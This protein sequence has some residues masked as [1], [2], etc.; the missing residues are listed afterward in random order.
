MAEDTTKKPII[1]ILKN[2]HMASTRGDRLSENSKIHSESGLLNEPNI[3]FEGN[4]PSNIRSSSYVEDV[5]SLSISTSSSH[6]VSPIKNNE[7]EVKENK[8][9]NLERSIMKFRK[10][11]SPKFWG[12]KE[13]TIHVHEEEKYEIHAVPNLSK[14]DREKHKKFFSQLDLVDGDDDEI[15]ASTNPTVRSDKK[16]TDELKKNNSEIMEMPSN[17]KLNTILSDAGVESFPKFLGRIYCGCVGIG[18]D[19]MHAGD[20]KKEVKINPVATV[21]SSSTN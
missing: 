13:E 4:K 2:S 9:I 7:E 16:G 20:T 1:S 18:D 5:R 17:K 14:K 6:S 19:A 10:M 12:K 15:I 8:K 3:S 11:L 21:C